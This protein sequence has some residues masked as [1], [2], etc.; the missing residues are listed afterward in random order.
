ML[1]I[2]PVALPVFVRAKSDR[3]TF[4][5]ASENEA[6]E[7]DRSAADVVRTGGVRLDVDLRADG[8]HVQPGR[9][10]DPGQARVGVGSLAVLDG[11]VGDY[12]RR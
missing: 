3:S 4:A 1:V 6:L 7:R 2:E 11:G 5:T 8:V 9:G 12:R 10:V